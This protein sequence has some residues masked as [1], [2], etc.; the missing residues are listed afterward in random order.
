[1]NKIRGL[2]YERYK[3]VSEFAR[4]IGWS[5]SKA[6]RIVNNRQDLSCDDIE[7]ITL[8]FCINTQEQF[9]DIFFAPLSTMWKNR[10]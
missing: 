4:D 9:F 8:L 10:Q 5:Y 1:M 2:V 3:T 7:K 6:N